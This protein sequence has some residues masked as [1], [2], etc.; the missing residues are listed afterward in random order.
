MKLIE[1]SDLLPETEWKD[2][3]LVFRNQSLGE[4]EQ[5]LERWFDVE[6]EFSDELVKA[7]R[8]TGILEHESILE[9][10]L[11]FGHSKYV[12]YRIKD[13]IITFFTKKQNSL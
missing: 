6:I 9:V 5:K 12:E 10:V 8:F 3:R 13:N 11:Y 2:G 4:L 7:R 1:V